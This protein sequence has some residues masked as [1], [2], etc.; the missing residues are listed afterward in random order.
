MTK[1][2]Q[3]QCY[4]RFMRPYICLMELP[5]QRAGNGNLFLG[6]TSVLG[7]IGGAYLLQCGAQC[8]LR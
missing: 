1:S 7:L 3:S 6:L 4:R 8:L 5:M 2:F